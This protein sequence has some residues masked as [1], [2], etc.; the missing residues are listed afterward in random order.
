MIRLYIIDDHYLVI[1]GFYLSFD[2]E[3]EDFKVVGGSLGIG[4]ALQKISPDGVDIIILD[5]FIQQSNPVSNFRRIHEAFPS[6]PIVILS[7]ENCLLWKVEMFRLG[8]KA[9]I[10]KAEDKSVMRQR[11]LR[12]AA[13]ETLMPEDVVQILVSKNASLAWA[14]T[15]PGL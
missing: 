6:I 3:S 9:Y 11:L 4:D 14:P 15:Y 10:N 2:M 8:A 5:L 13:G 12:I 1:E 7:H